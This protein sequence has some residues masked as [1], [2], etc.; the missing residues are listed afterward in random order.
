[1]TQPKNLHGNV[2]KGTSSIFY[3]KYVWLS[4][5]PSLK[6]ILHNKI[7][8]KFPSPYPTV[9]ILFSQN[10]CRLKNLSTKINQILKIRIKL[11]ASYVN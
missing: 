10:R 5:D 4:T 6:K 7:V 8:Q 3:G 11:D 2:C 9:C 1:M